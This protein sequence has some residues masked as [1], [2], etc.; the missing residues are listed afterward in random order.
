MR[1]NSLRTSLARPIGR[2]GSWPKVVSNNYEP[3]TSLS[4]LIIT[5]LTLRFHFLS[6][7]LPVQVEVAS[8]KKRGGKAVV[9]KAPDLADEALKRVEAFQT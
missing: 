3:S 4:F 7:V 9:K 5:E 6:Q 8:G 2:Q 1:T